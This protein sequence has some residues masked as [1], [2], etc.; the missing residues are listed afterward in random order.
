[1]IAF[2]SLPPG[3]QNLIVRQI[4]DAAQAATRD[5]RMQEAVAAAQQ[6]T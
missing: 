5:K 4:N 2:K 6:A 3:K 1:V